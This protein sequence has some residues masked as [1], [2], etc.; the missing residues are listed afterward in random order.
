VT[1]M[2]TAIVLKPIDLTHSHFKLDKLSVCYD[3]VNDEYVKKTCG[4][5]LD[6]KY[7]KSIP[8]MTITKSPRYAV[9]C[10][11]RIP[12]SEPCDTPQTVV[13][14]AGPYLPGVASY[15][16]E[17]NPDKISKAG[18]DDFFTLL[19]SC[20]DVDPIA[21][22]RTGKITRLDVALDLPGLDL[23]QVIVRSTRFQKHG[24]YSNRHGD[25]EM[26][27]LGT[28]R[29]RRIASYNKPVEGTMKTALR[30][31]TR[32]KPGCL[33][34][35]V[36]QLKNPFSNIELI[37]SNFSVSAG[38][39]IPSQSVADSVRIGGLKRALLPLDAGQRKA[40]KKAYEKAKSMLPVTDALWGNWSPTLIGYGLGQH[41]GAIS[42]GAPMMSGWQL[43]APL[44][45][46]P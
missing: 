27:Y 24:V 23:E 37:P 7:T 40:L 19:S 20:I 29:S 18:W 1:D 25:P 6:D 45:D 38:L 10:R 13:F 35:E 2:T 21:F 14:Q 16:W 39:S 17:G 31:E 15:R 28:P 46:I 41:L 44:A 22:F 43:A 8:G 32:L 12:Y 4:L 9:N 3:E 34:H 36:A 42:T 26:T 33:G 30:V 11:I 5:L